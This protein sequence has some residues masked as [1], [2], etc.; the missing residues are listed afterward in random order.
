MNSLVMLSESKELCWLLL[1]VQR[2]K[3]HNPLLC[4]R[5]R[6][7]VSEL[8]SPAR[9]GSRATQ[10]RRTTPSRAGGPDTRAVGKWTRG[11]GPEARHGRELG[12]CK[13]GSGQTSGRTKGS[14]QKGQKGRQPVQ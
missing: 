9:G 4:Q 3:M 12:A 11:L 6:R 13:R 1:G 10:G 5:T 7:P 2:K 14:K 8:N